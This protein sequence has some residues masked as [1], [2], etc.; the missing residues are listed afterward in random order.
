MNDSGVRASLAAIA[1]A[2]AC[3]AT[4]AVYL[5][6]R[7]RAQRRTLRVVHSGVATV[8]AVQRFESRALTSFFELTAF[9]VSVPFYA[10]ALPLLA[11]VRRAARARWRALRTLALGACLTR[12]CG[13]PDGQRAAVPQA[14]GADDTCVLRH[15]PARHAR[16]LHAPRTC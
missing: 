8:L 6:A 10:L 13:A 2:A 5:H 9:S 15:S 16:A 14:D 4:P 11:W 3:F 1:A 7:T 12:R